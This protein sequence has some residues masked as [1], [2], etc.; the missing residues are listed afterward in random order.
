VYDIYLESAA[1]RDLK[2]GFLLPYSAASSNISDPLPRIQDRQDVIKSWGP[3]VIG[4]SGWVIIESFT[5][6]MKKRIPLR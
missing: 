2:R 3:E 5:R 1:E 6:L 4:G